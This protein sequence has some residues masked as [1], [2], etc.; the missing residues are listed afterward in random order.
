MANTYYFKIKNLDCFVEKEGLQKVVYNVHWS[1][2]AQHETLNDLGN[3][4][5]VY[6]IGT[7]DVSAPDPESFT[8]FDNL[9]EEMIISWIEPQLDIE[10][11]RSYLDSL[12]DE[13]IAPTKISL[14]LNTS[15][16]ENA[17]TEQQSQTVVDA[18]ETEQVEASESTAT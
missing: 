11:M 7:K 4:N 2:Y 8:S 3:P 14:R 15:I 12:L 16:K 17:N 10:S 5:E 18:S 6:M 9:T 13:K 1:Y